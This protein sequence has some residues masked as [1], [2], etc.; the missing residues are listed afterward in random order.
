MLLTALCIHCCLYQ[1]QLLLLLLSTNIFLVVLQVVRRMY[2]RALG[3]S[4]SG[5]Q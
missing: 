1:L 3:E 5:R 4:M 2:V